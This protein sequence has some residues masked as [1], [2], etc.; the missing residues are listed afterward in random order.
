MPTVHPQFEG[1]TY[2][3][4][5]VRTSE[6]ATLGT[7]VV[8]AK[9]GDK[10]NNGQWHSVKLVKEEDKVSGRGAG[11]NGMVNCWRVGGRVGVW[12]V[13][14]VNCMM[15]GLAGGLVGTDL[16]GMMGGLPGG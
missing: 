6:G 16:N 5:D 9:D 1:E 4:L 14:D 7:D 11:L 15:G 2:V 3:T 10:I 8:L 12:V 13:T